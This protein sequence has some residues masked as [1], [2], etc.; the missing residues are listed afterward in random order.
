MFSQQAIARRAFSPLGQNAQTWA[1]IP[2]SSGVGASLTLTQKLASALGVSEGTAQTVLLGGG[3]L[4]AL[5]LLVAV[6][7][8]RR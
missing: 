2:I 5:L 8:R 1:T 6:K 4:A 7:G 3:A